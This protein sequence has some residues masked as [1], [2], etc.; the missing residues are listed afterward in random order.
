MMSAMKAANWASV[1]EMR[2]EAEMTATKRRRGRSATRTKMTAA[3]SRRLIALETRRG[4]SSVHF[5]CR[6]PAVVSPRLVNPACPSSKLLA[7]KP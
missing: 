6:I 3:A 4:A 1:F 2:P 7:E 5:Y